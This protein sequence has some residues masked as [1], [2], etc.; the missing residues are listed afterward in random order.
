MHLIKTLAAGVVGAENGTAT[1]YRRGTSTRVGYYEEFE[2]TTFVAPAAIP[3]DENGGAVA[4][5]NEN[6][7]VLVKSSTGTTVRNFVDGVGA[8]AVEVRSRS[9]IGTNYETAAVAASEPTTLRSV[10]DKVITSFGTTDFNVLVNGV[11]TAISAAASAFT[12]MFFNV[13]AAAYGALGDASNDD[14]TEIGLAIAAAAVDGGV[15]YFPPGVYNI[16]SVLTVPSNVSLLGCGTNASIIQTTHASNNVL[17]TSGTPTYN[18]QVIEGLTLRASTTNSGYIV[19][20]T[21]AA[22]TTFRD[23][24]FGGANSTAA[25]GLVNVAVGATKYIKFDNCTFRTG[26]SASKMVVSSLANRTGRIDLTGCTFI[27][28]ASLTHSAPTTMGLLEGCCFF[29][30]D[31]LF[32]L[33]ASSAGTFSCI[34]PGAIQWGQVRGCEFLN[35][36]GA[37]VTCFALGALGASSAALVWFDEEGNQVSQASSNLTLYSMTHSATGYFVN[38]GTRESR[39]KEYAVSS[40]PTALDFLNYGVICVVSSVAGASTYTAVVGPV[41][42]RQSLLLANSNGTNRTMTLSTGIKSFGGYSIT[43][44]TGGAG[45]EFTAMHPTSGGHNWYLTGFSGTN[46]TLGTDSYT[47]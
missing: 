25:S 36:T 42:A 24:Y 12:G 20:F 5:V 2:G 16:S 38:L 21:A 10:L 43:A 3:L 1:L 46:G 14:T 22:K 45:F 39:Y 19:T 30:Y 6:V 13:K 7:D 11:D 33:A 17:T 4:Y 35:T 26:G 8:S 9:F 29:V 27:T 31:C 23:C 28:P 37:T 44:S 40:T 34:Y 18:A 47:V 41:G 15:V 32:D